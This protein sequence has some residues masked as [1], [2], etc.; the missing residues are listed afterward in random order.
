MKRIEATLIVLLV[1]CV[2][3]GSNP[4][5]SPSPA[6]S[7]PS[8]TPSPSPVPTPSPSPMPTFAV[9]GV[10]RDGAGETPLGNVTVGF[11]DVRFN[12]CR[13]KLPPT[14]TTVTDSNGRYSLDVP[15]ASSIPSVLSFNRPGFSEV[16]GELS[17]KAIRRPLTINVI[18]PRAACASARVGF[19]TVRYGTDYIDLTWPDVSGAH[20]Y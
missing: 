20:D 14:V 17:M 7:S 9:S 15:A 3:C 19:A 18:L 8:P 13:E 11:G 6:P 5:T 2:G 1:V 10:V 4:S 12:D 16:C